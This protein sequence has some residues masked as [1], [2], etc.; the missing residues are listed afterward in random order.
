MHLTNYSVNK[1]S[2][3]F[4][5]DE[6]ID[7]G[8]KRT[9]KYFSSWLSQN[10][11]NVAEL[12]ARVHVRQHWW[13]AACDQWLCALF[14]LPGCDHKDTHH[15]SSQPCALLPSLQTRKHTGQQVSVLRDTG[16]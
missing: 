13:C 1:H 3:A 11:Y 2:S 9:L 15:G 4:N 8:S 7:K 16:L 14:V 12:W 10:G 5:N 6:G